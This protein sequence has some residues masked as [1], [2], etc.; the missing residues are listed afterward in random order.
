M[1][2]MTYELICNTCGREIPDCT[3]YVEH[4][5]IVFC[6]DLCDGEYCDREDN[7]E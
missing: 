6:N 4:D 1:I 7:D 2:D 3:R 5:G